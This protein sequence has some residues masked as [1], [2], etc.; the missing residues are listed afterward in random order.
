M[1][2]TM[3]INNTDKFLQEQSKNVSPRD[4]ELI[5][6]AVAVLQ[7]NVSHEEDAP[8]GNKRCM[9]PSAERF[10]GI[11][12]WDTA[13][14]A[15]GLSRMDVDFAAEHIEAFC[16][17]QFEN[18]MFPDV[19]FTSGSIVDAFTKP[20][21]MA[22]AC[23]TVYRRGAGKD[24]LERMYP[25]LSD[26]AV[27]WETER[28]SGEMFHYDSRPDNGVKRNDW[29]GNDSG[30]DNSVRWD[31]EPHKLWAIDLNCYMVMTYR[32][33][34]FIANELGKD[35]SAWSEK[36]DTLSDKINSMLWNE[37]LGCYTDR[38]FES[39]EYSNVLSPASFTPLFIHIAPQD[40]AE[41]CNTVA[42]EK[43][44]FGMPTVSYDNPNYGTDYWRGPTWLN[45][46]YFAAKGLKDY[47]FVDT[48]DRIK[49]TILG[50]VEND[51][52][53]IHENYNSTTGEGLCAEY[54]SWSAVFVMEF[55]LNF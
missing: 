5:K 49:E 44:G 38:N 47:H 37:K 26:N 2:N 35:G 3:M 54:F 11:W 4:Y 19:V 29:T 53:M 48:A 21:V 24:F 27:F 23:E 32:S 13:F 28:C 14:H 31:N 55:I 10:Q 41:M 8:W 46:A 15:V 6:K 34:A 36:A 25:R 16:E 22:W 33:L 7:R 12:N 39:G 42:R 18:G 1:D 50:W 40:R 30:W 43:F 52:D 20:P 45:V 9:L 17:F 51:G